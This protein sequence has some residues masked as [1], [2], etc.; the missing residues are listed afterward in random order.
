LDKELKASGRH[1][2]KFIVSLQNEFKVEL[3]V[4]VKLDFGSFGLGLE[5]LVL[6]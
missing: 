2:V 3:E 4:F 6:G 5:R 1:A